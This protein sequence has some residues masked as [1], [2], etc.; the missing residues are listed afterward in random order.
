MAD[1]KPIRCSGHL[2]PA[3]AATDHCCLLA[4]GERRSTLLRRL[5]PAGDE[6]DYL[7]QHSRGDRALM[8]GMTSREI[9]DEIERTP[10]RPRWRVGF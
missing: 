3:E 10:T 8:P 6:H 5:L 2:S 7:P 1:R 4:H 9:L